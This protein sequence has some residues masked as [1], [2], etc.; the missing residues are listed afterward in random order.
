MGRNGLWYLPLT[1]PISGEE[2]SGSSLS[3]ARF[4]NPKSAA[5]SPNVTTPSSFSPRS[6]FTSLSKISRSGS[7]TRGAPSER[8]TPLDLFPMLMGCQF[9]CRR[10][11]DGENAELEEED[12]GL[13]YRATYYRAPQRREREETRSV[14]FE[15]HSMTWHLISW[16]VL[17]SS[18]QGRTR[19]PTLDSPSLP[20]WFVNTRRPRPSFG[21][22]Y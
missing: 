21:C 1:T 3:R 22:C 19:H 5:I 20:A 17:R 7:L 10:R 18:P 12:L 15:V 11:L 8:I 2:M 6:F 4:S 14:Y 13:T 9:V 16:F